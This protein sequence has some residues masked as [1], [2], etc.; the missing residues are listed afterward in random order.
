MR[1]TFLLLTTLLGLSLAEAATNVTISRYEDNL[2]RGMHEWKLCA[3]NSE[4]FF[5]FLINTETMESGRTYTLADMD[6]S[7][8]YLHNLNAK[9]PFDDRYS[10]V[11]FT[12]TVSPEEFVTIEVTLT[13]L[14]HGDYHLLYSESVLE[15]PV[16]T[17]YLE[18]PD[19]FVDDYTVNNHFI[20]FHGS[21]ATYAVNLTCNNA[22]FDVD[23]V[24]DGLGLYYEMGKLDE[25]STSLAVLNG[26][27]LKLKYARA[28]VRSV[29][30]GQY[31]VDAYLQDD[32]RHAYIVKMQTVDRPG[33]DTI[34]VR[35]GNMQIHEY[36]SGEHPQVSFQC[37]NDEYQMSLWV[38]SEQIDGEYYGSRINSASIYYTEQ[39]EW[40]ISYV[41]G[42]VVVETVDNVTTLRGSLLMSEGDR[43]EIDFT[44]AEWTALDNITNERAHARKQINH[45]MLIIHRDD[46][47]YTILGERL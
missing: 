43:Y 31:A 25:S 14:Q 22:S 47:Q 27:G 35:G 40:S 39:T 24:Y 19:A 41:A 20:A 28:D 29:G 45:G 6:E 23:G 16:D 42:Y 46:A 10:D 12:W 37:G 3:E 33:N 8:S 21:D 38:N 1:K 9:S 36:T 26:A 4:D 18:I 15:E 13:T 7:G 34:V 11:A 5:F 2:W 30:L 32:A 44:T 17:T